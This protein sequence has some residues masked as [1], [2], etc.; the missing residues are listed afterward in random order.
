MPAA[1]DGMRYLQLDPEPGRP[2]TVS[3]PLC[4]PIVRG[5]GYYWGE[6]WMRAFGS[7]HVLLEFFYS[8]SEC[9]LD[10]KFSDAVPDANWASGCSAWAMAPWDAEWLTIRAVATGV[11]SGTVY[12]DAFLAG[13]E[14]CPMFEGIP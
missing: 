11:F 9:G 5:M 12:L 14:V 3:V 1:P 8:K 13:P 7:G 4:A 6:S 2:V 10:G